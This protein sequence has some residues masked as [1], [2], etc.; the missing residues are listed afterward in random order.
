MKDINGP[1]EH[2]FEMCR[3]A[4]YSTYGSSD[5]SQLDMNRYRTEITK[6]SDQ[7]SR[8]FVSIKKLLA[9]MVGSGDHTLGFFAWGF[10]LIP[11]VLL[12]AVGQIVLWIAAGFRNAREV[13][14]HFP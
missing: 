3:T 11:P 2:I 9:A 4:A 1:A 10:I 5:S 13:D 12:C 6:C 14:N 8:D 7:Q